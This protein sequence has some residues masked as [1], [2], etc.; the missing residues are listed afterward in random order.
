MKK[1]AR[2]EPGCGTCHH[3]KH[4]HA[5]HGACVKEKKPWRCSCTKFDN[6]NDYPTWAYPSLRVFRAKK[7]REIKNLLAAISEAETGTAYMPGYE[8]FKQ[9][10]ALA[11]DIRFL[12]RADKWGR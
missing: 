1:K 10:I 9:I 2:R 12:I 11:R 6:R 7:R 5:L 3:Q 8:Q 4:W